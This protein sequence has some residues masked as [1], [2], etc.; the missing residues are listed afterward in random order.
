MKRKLSVKVLVLALILAIAMP[1]GAFASVSELTM[2]S[3]A[4]GVSLAGSP[5]TNYGKGYDDIEFQWSKT[6]DATHVVVFEGVTVEEGFTLS[7][8]KDLDRPYQLGQAVRI[9][10]LDARPE[11]RQI[12]FKILP[13][14]G[15]EEELQ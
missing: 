7:L 3:T 12:D 15:C 2:D 1:T 13:E 8:D 11:D 14:A 10:V 4:P 9:K 5:Y 6:E